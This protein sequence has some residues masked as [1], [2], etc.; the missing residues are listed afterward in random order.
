MIRNRWRIGFLA[1]I[2]EKE[3]L[4]QEFE[5]MKVELEADFP[6]NSVER[7]FTSYILNKVEEC[8]S[9]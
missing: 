9:D 1:L 3:E 2:E 7:K 8:I 4:Q 6:S 5:S